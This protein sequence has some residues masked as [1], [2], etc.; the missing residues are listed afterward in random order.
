MDI[1]KLGQNLF[2][3]TSSAAGIRSKNL[4]DYLEDK[5]KKAEAADNFTMVNRPTEGMYN[6]EPIERYKYILNQSQANIKISQVQGDPEKSLKQANDILNQAILPPV[7]DNP[8]SAEVAMA[9]LVKRMAGSR[10]DLAA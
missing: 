2:S 1:G 7:T 8:D 5:N 10:L 4:N 6:L 3:G 9:M